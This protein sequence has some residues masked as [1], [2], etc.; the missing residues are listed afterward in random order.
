MA[1]RKTSVKKAAKNVT[2][3]TQENYN[4]ILG[5]YSLMYGIKPQ[6]LGTLCM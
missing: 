1:D 4:A 5:A 3:K 2:E 6:I